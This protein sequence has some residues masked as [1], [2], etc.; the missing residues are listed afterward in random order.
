M[1]PPRACLLSALHAACEFRL[2]GQSADCARA[3]PHCSTPRHTCMELEAPRISCGL[4][5][6]Q[7]LLST[8]LLRAHRR[9]RL[10]AGRA[11]QRAA[12]GRGV[13]ERHGGPGRTGARRR[14]RARA[15]RAVLAAAR[16]CG[17][18]AP[19]PALLC[20]RA[21]LF[22]PAPAGGLPWL[23]RERQLSTLPCT[24]LQ[25]AVC[26]SSRVSNS[27]VHAFSR[28]SFWTKHATR[29]C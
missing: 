4:S 15:L 6:M 12:G 16:R 9:N 20:V 27:C 23:M 5:G 1:H 13:P 17:T 3:V 7:Y 8:T 10:R 14:R 18:A 22:Q 25:A 26:C 19:L 21:R 29:M 2:A 11:R 28:A 24:C